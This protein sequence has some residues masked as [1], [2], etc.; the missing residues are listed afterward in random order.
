[1]GGPCKEAV[2]GQSLHDQDYA[3]W[4][5]PI[6]TEHVDISELQTSSEIYINQHESSK[7]EREGQDCS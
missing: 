5:G 6:D 7:R 3:E 4:K 2:E 1:M